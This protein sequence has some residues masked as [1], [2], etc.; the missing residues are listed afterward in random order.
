MPWQPVPNSCS[1]IKIL[2]VQSNFSFGDISVSVE[3]QIMLFI[4][5]ND[6]SV[7]VEFQFWWNLSFGNI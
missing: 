7:M 5:F 6:I 3:F 1:K 2:E 4:I